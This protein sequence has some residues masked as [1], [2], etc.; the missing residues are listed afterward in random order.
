MLFSCFYAYFRLGYVKLRL[1]LLAGLVKGVRI[2]PH[3]PNERGPHRVRKE[4]WIGPRK[5]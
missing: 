2:L 1:G 4:V 5:G 3:E